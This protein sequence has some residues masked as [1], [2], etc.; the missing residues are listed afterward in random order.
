MA[1]SPSITILESDM[2]AYTVTSSDTVLAIVG[3]ATKGPIGEPTLVTSR[4]EFNEIFGTTVT[5]SPYAALA[6]Y[7]AF[8]QG[9]KII[10]DRVATA[11]GDNAAIEAEV[12]V[13]NLA[14]VTAGTMGLD[15]GGTTITVADATDYTLDITIDDGTT[16]T[17][18]ATSTSTSM[19]VAEIKT[20][21]DA[22]LLIEGTGATSVL[23][24]DVITITSGT[25]G[26]ES[27][28]LIEAGTGGT[29]LIGTDGV[30]TV[31]AIAGT[32]SEAQTDHIKI[33]SLEKGSSTN[34]ISV[35]KTS[36]T[37][38]VSGAA[39]H[40]IEV[41]YDGVLKETFDE[42][43][44]VVADAEYFATVVNADPDNGGSD[45][46][47]FTVLEG[48]TADA[49]NTDFQNGTYTLGSG[50]TAF[51]TTDTLDAY[52]F[53]LG[54][55]GYDASASEGANEALFIAE[56]ETTAELGNMEAFDF[57]ILIAPDMPEVTVQ[58]KALELCEFRKDFIYVVDPPFALKYDEVTDWHN[59]TGGHGRTT[60]LDSSYGTLYWSWLKEY[61]TDTKE[62]VWCPP[63][64]FMAEKFMEVD[65]LY[66]PW[67][68][69]AGDLRGKITAADYEKSPSFAQREI[70][71][72][73]YNAVNPIVNFVSKGIEV[74][75]QKTLV[76][77]NTSLNRLNVRRMIIFAK[78]LIKVSLEG[79]IF[80]PHNPDSW[81]KASNLVTAILEPIR[82]AGGI[83]K[84]S[85]IIDDTV[86]TAD[87]IAQ[88]IMKGT[89]KIIPMNTIEIIEITM[90]VHKSGASLDE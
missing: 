37:N 32:S 50:D 1:K 61:N 48:L 72:G 66:G 30:A 76:R 21:I 20:A 19:T 54:L 35:V 14:P 2:S 3:Y 46:V 13:H 84:Y 39:V 22:A 40:K 45:Y 75:G 78:K 9:N 49:L 86:N 27:T 57:H 31:P 12:I 4:S 43:S 10:F 47:S 36:R 42:V 16:V 8:N 17:A 11:T 29:N 6:A 41:Y 77:T 90:Q 82:Q 70:L 74:Y 15:V 80:E 25:M 65:R 55:D 60:A 23:E 83:D 68:A 71:Y 87:V 7:R 85:V 18:T 63:S 59:G 79:M 64:V 52:D 51:T 81:R 53:V 38:P 33:K 24:T 62:Y 5:G 73:D 89:I 58:D 88:N 28:V 34:L 44:L 67:A 69:P 26:T 56:L